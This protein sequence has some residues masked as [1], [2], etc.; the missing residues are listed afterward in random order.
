MNSDSISRHHYVYAIVAFKD[1]ILYELTKSDLYPRI[2]QDPYP[3]PSRKQGPTV[4]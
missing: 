3:Q 1:V 4:S 2:L